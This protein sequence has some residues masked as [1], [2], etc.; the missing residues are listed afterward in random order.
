MCPYICC[1]I[2]PSLRLSC[3]PQPFVEDN[4]GSSPWEGAGSLASL[5]LETSGSYSESIFP[6]L[7]P[8]SASAEDVG[9]IPGLLYTKLPASQPAF[10][11]A[12]QGAAPWWWLVVIA[13]GGPP[14][15]LTREVLS[16]QKLR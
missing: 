12:T 10:S 14:L 2:P 15:L 6:T 16:G 9:E 13:G 3:F 8:P 4:S 7:L 11:V 5:S 1:A